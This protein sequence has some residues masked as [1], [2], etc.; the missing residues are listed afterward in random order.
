[1]RTYLAGAF[2]S[3]GESTHLGASDEIAINTKTICV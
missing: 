2:T 3:K 1:M